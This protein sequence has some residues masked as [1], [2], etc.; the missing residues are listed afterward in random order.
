MVGGCNVLLCCG[1]VNLLQ[2]NMEDMQ[3]RN[4]MYEGGLKAVY[5]AMQANIDPNIQ[6]VSADEIASVIPRDTKQQRMKC[7]SIVRLISSTMYFGAE[8]YW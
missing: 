3:C 8:T 4:R 5:E 2:F 7:A 1:L 6:P